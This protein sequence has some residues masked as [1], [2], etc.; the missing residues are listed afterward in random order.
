MIEFEQVLI[1]NYPE[2]IDH[3]YRKKADIKHR[4]NHGYDLL[5]YVGTVG[6]QRINRAE[7]ILVIDS[8]TDTVHVLKNIYGKQQGILEDTSSLDISLL[9]DY[10]QTVPDKKIIQYVKKTHIDDS[11]LF[12][13][14]DI[15][16]DIE[17]A[18][19][20][21]DD[22]EEI[23]TFFRDILEEDILEEED[24]YEEEGLEEDSI[25]FIKILESKRDTNG[26]FEI[27][28]LKTLD[29]DELYG[30]IIGPDLGDD[31]KGIIFDKKFPV[32]KVCEFLNFAY[33]RG[34]KDGYN[35]RDSEE[36]I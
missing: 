21:E 1:L 19:E 26:P 24:D 35:D 13:F 17:E 28:F 34:F 2:D 16:K 36:D 14:E 22:Y 6:I 23:D 31:V 33:N 11:H 12:S 4:N 25:N 30:A 10:Q 3:E 18:I 9:C 27:S 5:M 7:V 20:E 32:E 15:E 8:R 29:N